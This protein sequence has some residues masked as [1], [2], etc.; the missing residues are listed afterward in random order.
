MTKLS[1]SGDQLDQAILR[2]IQATEDHVNEYSRLR[3][4][5][6]KGENQVVSAS[7]QEDDSHLDRISQSNHYLLFTLA[8]ILA[9]GAGIKASS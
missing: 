2:N 6:V 8:A 3:G 1:S 5:R 7:G 9:V 4:K